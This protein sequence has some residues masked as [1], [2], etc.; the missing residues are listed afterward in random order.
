MKK[1]VL[2]PICLI[3]LSCTSMLDK[4]LV[5]KDSDKYLNKICKNHET[6]CVE[7]RNEYLR[8]LMHIERGK[9]GRRLLLMQYKKRPEDVTFRDILKPIQ[10]KVRVGDKVH[11]GIVFYLDGK[12]GGLVCAEF[13]QSKGA[14]WGCSGKTIV[15]TSVMSR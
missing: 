6:H 1:F 12:G 9:D 8:F 2:F 7:I 10:E 14:K 13:D 4:K 3:F 15:G 5:D 11:G